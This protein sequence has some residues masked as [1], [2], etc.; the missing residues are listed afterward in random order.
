[1][2]SEKSN[3]IINL[4]GYFK[5]CFKNQKSD[6]KL[7]KHEKCC[8]IQKKFKLFCRLQIVTN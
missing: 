2:F 7:Q 8:E 5:G 3:K 6:S 4:R 1:M